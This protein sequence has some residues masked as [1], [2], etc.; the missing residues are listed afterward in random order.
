[1]NFMQRSVAPQ[2]DST[3]A[4]AMAPA[5]VRWSLSVIS[6]RAAAANVA[7]S[8]I[9]NPP[10]FFASAMASW[11]FVTPILENWDKIPLK[12]YEKGVKEVS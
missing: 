7:W 6:E 5:A 10:P 8:S 4:R 3:K 11:E 12:V 2:F 1:M 9:T